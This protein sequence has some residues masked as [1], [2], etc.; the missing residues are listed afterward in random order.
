MKCGHRKKTVIGKLCADI[1]VSVPVIFDK[2][3]NQSL[4]SVRKARLNL[5]EI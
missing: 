1:G 3:I 4:K 2:G 5:D